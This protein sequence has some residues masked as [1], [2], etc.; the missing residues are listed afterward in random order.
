MKFCKKCLTIY[1][2]QDIKVG[3]I[4]SKPN[5]FGNII[6]HPNIYTDFL[7]ELKN[8]NYI[9]TKFSLNNRSRLTINLGFIQLMEFLKQV[10]KKISVSKYS[11]FIQICGP[12]LSNDVNEKIKEL[13]EILELLTKWVNS[14]PY[15]KMLIGIF[16]FNT[17]SERE[18]LNNYLYQNEICFSVR[19]KNF[20]NNYSLVTIRFINHDDLKREINRLKYLGKKMG[21]YHMKFELLK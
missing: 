21:S 18:K 14:L 2:D 9:P 12:L 3:G 17:E 1:D 7:D 16:F 11:D 5:C 19:D 6:Q 4:C 13:L 15:L 20:H 10:P 8:K